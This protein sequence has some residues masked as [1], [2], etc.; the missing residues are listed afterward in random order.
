MEDLG[1]YRFGVGGNEKYAYEADDRG[2]S[3]IHVLDHIP[4]LVVPISTVVN[5]LVYQIMRNRKESSIKR[6]RESHRL[7]TF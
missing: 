5:G 1:E 2:L 7:N 6:E 3:V 4:I